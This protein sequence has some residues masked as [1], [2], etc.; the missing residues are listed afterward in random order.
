MKK[1]TAFTLVELLVVI[2]IIG[3]LVAILLPAINAARSSARSVSCKNKVRQLSLAA[4]NYESAFGFFPPARFQPRPGDL[5][6]RQC[7]GSGVSWIVHILPYIEQTSFSKDWNLYDD[8]ARHDLAI[9][10]RALDDLAC[11][12]R[13]SA[14]SMAHNPERVYGTS[15]TSAKS[16]SSARG[17]WPPE[18]IPPLAAG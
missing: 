17:S 15:Q 1:Q 8:F 5:D 4:I 2:A 3:I 11:P 7:G 9:R 10:T 13:R 12:E 14:D 6:R 16:R 18:L